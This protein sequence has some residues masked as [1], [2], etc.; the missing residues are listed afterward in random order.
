MAGVS[1]RSVQIAFRRAYGITPSA[2]LLACRLRHARLLL[3]SAG[4]ATSVTQVA[5]DCG[6]YHLGRFSLQ[7]KRAFAESPSATLRR[8][9]D[10]RLGGH[11]LPPPA[12][13][14]A[15]PS[16]TD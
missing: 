4:P 2:A 16:T 15:M 14:A 7:Y 1:V 9:I 8:A 3:R 13:A 6:F 12:P 10:R 11:V 5:L